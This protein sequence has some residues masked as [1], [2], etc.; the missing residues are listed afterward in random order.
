MQL[1][2]I[3]IDVVGPVFLVALVGYIWS[4]SG[5]PFDPRFVSLLVTTVGTPSL[6]IDNLSKAGLSLNLLGQIALACVLCHAIAL[7]AG[8]VFVRAMGESTTV[9]LPALGF[10]NSGNMGLPLAL[11]AFGETGL[12]LAIAFYATA[13]LLQFTVGQSIAAG[14]MNPL[15]ILRMP[16]VWALIVAITLA[17]TG[18]QLPS[19]AAR[20]IH[21]M[22]GLM[23]PLMLLSLG[24]S[25]ASLKMASMQRATIFALARL[26]GGFAVG[27]LVAWL[28]GL[29]GAARGV[30]VAQ[31]AMPAAVFNYMFAE[32]YNNRPEEVAGVVVIS[33]LLAIL[34]LPVFLLTVL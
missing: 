30:V 23:V 24:Y 12:A 13:S 2:S 28:L 25:L 9:F 14:G 3:L 17:V 20:A 19:V 1:F 34:F 8:Y 29:E 32:R 21:I 18:V 31:A 11:F 4:R 6:I 7:A 15:A 5:A 22:G 10:P 27:W 33:T 16:L 26:I